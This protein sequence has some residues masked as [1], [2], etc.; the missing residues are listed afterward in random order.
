MQE[1]QINEKTMD[2]KGEDVRT[3]TNVVSVD[4]LDFDGNHPVKHQL[5]AGVRQGKYQLSTSS[6]RY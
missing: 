4:E 5:H 3:R 6:I 1:V 2:E